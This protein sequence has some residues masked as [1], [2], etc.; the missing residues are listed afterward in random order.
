[1]PEGTYEKGLAGEAQ[2]EAYLQNR[3]MVPLMR[4][5]R[6]P[7]GEIDLVMMDAGTLVFIEV[8]ARATGR[9]GAGLVSVGARKRARIVKTALYY[10]TEHPCDCP[11]R[12]D[13]LEVTREGWQHIVGAFEG[14]EFS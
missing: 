10:L 14:S 13:A 2:A 5:Y 1:M 11:C 6:S 7:F 8:K 12:F 4:R 3:G 9:A